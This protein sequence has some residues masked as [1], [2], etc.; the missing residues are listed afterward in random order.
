MQPF[1]K[2]LFKVLLKRAEYKIESTYD[3]SY[4]EICLQTETRAKR[5]NENSCVG[6]VSLCVNFFFKFCFIPFNVVLA[7]YLVKWREIMMCKCSSST[8][9]QKN[10]PGIWETNRWG[11]CMGQSHESLSPVLCLP[12][13]SISLSQQSRLWGKQ[14]LKKPDDLS[15]AVWG[16]KMRDWM[17]L[18]TILLHSPGPALCES[19]PCALHRPLASSSLV[20]RLKAQMADPNTDILNQ[21]IWSEAPESECNQPPRQLSHTGRDICEPLA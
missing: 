20:L 1:G 7:F 12:P 5:K 17:R 2:H 6:M 3:Y 19:G 4:V 14:C 18:Q 9:I 8:H 16:Y 13:S 10:K 15:K 21:R 11:L